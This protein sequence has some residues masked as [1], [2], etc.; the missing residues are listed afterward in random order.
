MKQQIF[1]VIKKYIDSDFFLEKPK[2]MSLGHYATPVAFSLAKELKKSPMII[3]EELV[4]KIQNE[5]VFEKI[6]AV[7]GYIN[8]KLSQK[9]MDEFVT[10]ALTNE[11]D[12]AKGNNKGSILIEFVSAN[13]T[14][15]LHIGHTRGAVVGDSLCRIGRHLGYSITSEYYIN[16]A[17]NQIDL[18]G[19]SIY[20]RA[21]ESIFGKNVELPEKYYRGE[22]IDSIIEEIISKYGKEFL[23]NKDNLNKMS[24]FGK[25]F[26]MIEIPNEL[27][28]INVSIENYVSEKSLFSKWNES[29]EKLEKNNKTYKKDDKI[30]LK[31]SEYG[32]E[33]DR[34]IVRE[35]GVPTYIAG[36]IIYHDDKFQ[37]DYDHYINIWGAD[38]HGYIDRIKASV[39]F[40][41][42]D[43]KKLEII[44]AQMVSLLKDGQPFKMSKR[45]GTSIL[46]SDIVSEIGSDAL[47]FIKKKKKSDT[48]LEFDVNELK[49]SDN[50]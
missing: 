6:T 35:D 29:F 11:D 13:P 17:G 40:L 18:L 50:S 30:W 1:S 3:A 23:D 10:W 41:G 2:D 31:S 37:R 48:H 27:K 21:Q 8:F 24:E 45:A 25:D 20:L 19:I 36:D 47:R 9:F 39:K 12:F 32:D 46:L 38:H 22:Y 26:M 4:K 7:N 15:P 5:D 14:G 43:E 16:D 44:L 34:V 49:K 28:S 42:Y 33:K